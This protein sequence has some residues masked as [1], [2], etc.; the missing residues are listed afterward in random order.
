MLKWGL[1][2]WLAAAPAE[3]PPVFIP[4]ERFT[5]AW[6][7]SIEKV[8]WE[9]DYEVARADA[10]GQAPRLRA[11]LARIRGSAA[12]MEPPPHSVWRTGWY[13]YPASDPPPEGLRL[14]RSTYTADY[15]LCTGG[16]CLPFGHW[17][18]SDGGITLLRACSQTHS[19]Q[20]PNAN[21]P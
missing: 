19:A 20:T 17:L 3:T 10:T 12:G 11:G 7:H 16:R 18:P 15:E 4:A 9:E 2:L 14:T 21:H 8:R 13:E 5:L 6:L 1:C